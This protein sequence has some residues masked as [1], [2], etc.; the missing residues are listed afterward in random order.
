METAVK[1][2]KTEAKE[3]IEYWYKIVDELL[4]HDIKDVLDETTAQNM[5]SVD[6]SFGGDHGKGRFR[7]VI[8]L[9][10]R[11]DGNPPIKKRFVLG[12]IDCKNDSVDILKNTFMV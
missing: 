10:I 2:Y 6:M 5:A 4:D 1:S 8:K 7:L 9:I 12:E 11:L 3:S